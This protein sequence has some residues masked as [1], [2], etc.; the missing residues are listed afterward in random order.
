[1]IK[2]NKIKRLAQLTCCILVISELN[3]LES[4]KI[5]QLPRGCD[6]HRFDLM[7]IYWNI[8]FMSTRSESGIRCD[9]AGEIFKSFNVLTWN[10]TDK[11]LL[12]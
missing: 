3:F 10:A 2:H 5:C 7:E 12:F 1:M 6:F 4:L 11:L 9:V 8:E